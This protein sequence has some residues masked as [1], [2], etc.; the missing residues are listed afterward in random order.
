MVVAWS[1]ASQRPNVQ[2]ASKVRFRHS[3]RSRSAASPRSTADRY[4]AHPSRSSSAVPV[5]PGVVRGQPYDVDL[6]RRARRVTGGGDDD[7]VAATHQ[8][9][10]AVRLGVEELP[11]LEEGE[12][13]APAGPHRWLRRRR[14]PS[15]GD[16]SSRVRRRMPRMRRTPASPC[17]APARGPV[18][19]GPVSGG[20]RMC[21]R[22][23]VGRCRGE[24]ELVTGCPAPLAAWPPGRLGGAGAHLTARALSSG[25]ISLA[26]AHSAGVTQERALNLGRF[27]DLSM[28][29]APLPPRKESPPAPPRVD[30]PNRPANTT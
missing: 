16:I 21:D 26:C 24:P 30:T 6:F 12:D 3:L 14:A 13:E 18:R 15:R 20:V 22:S 2:V 19:A 5:G 11:S 10:V 17:P 8:L 1:T 27:T 29:P 23:H 9:G 7:R 4:V 25:S 28:A